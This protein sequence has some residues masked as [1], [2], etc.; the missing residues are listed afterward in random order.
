M[1]P[2][3]H[4]A[5]P[6]LTLAIKLSLPNPCAGAPAYPFQDFLHVHISNRSIPIRHSAARSIVKGTKCSNAHFHNSQTMHRLRTSSL[7]PTLSSI[8][9]GSLRFGYLSPQR[10]YSPC[11]FC[12]WSRRTLSISAELRLSKGFPSRE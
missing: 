1:F 4:I 11:Q 9:N 2:I 7:T 6:P 10:P 5:I 12:S 8:V 3:F